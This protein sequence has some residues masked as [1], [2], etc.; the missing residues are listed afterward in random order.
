M[1][2]RYL[3]LALASLLLGTA[4][5]MPG[6]CPTGFGELIVTVVPD[7]WPNEIS[8]DLRSGGNV[9]ASGGV[10]GGT[11]CIPLNTC[12][13]FNMYDGYGDGITG[14][15]GY[16]VTLDGNTIASGGSLHGN[17]YG[18]IQTTE[19]NCPPGFSCGNPLVVGEGTH[20]APAADTWY[21]FT[22]PQSGSYLVTT[23]GLADCDTR[24]WVYD[25]CTGLV[26]DNSPAGTMYYADGGC[27]SNAELAQ[28]S[29]NL[30]EGDVVWIR[31]GHN[32]GDCAATIPWSVNYSGPIVGCTMINSCNYNPLA[33]VDDGS[34]IPW[35]DPD[36]PQAPDLTVDQQRLQLSL[37][38]GTTTVQQ[39]NCYIAEG[40][41]TGYGTREILRFDTR[42]ANIG[43]LDYY[44]G[45]P[46]ANP[47]QF[48][49]QNCHGH[50]HYKG[51]AEY[52]LYDDQGQEL[53]IGFKNG[54]CVMDIDCNGGG[55]GQYGCGNM[56]ISA[57][58]ADVYGSGTSCNWLDITGV[59]EGTYTLVVRTNW[60]NDPDA[61]GR[62]ESN[63]FNNWAQVCIRIDRTP[64]LAVSIE[65]DC[66]PYVD[67]LGEIYGS[68]QMDCM[69]DCAGLALIGDL[70]NDSYQDALDVNE[71]VTGIL[72]NDLTPVPC[73]DIDQD[74]NLTVTDAALLAYCNYWN[75]YNHPPDSAAVH[76]HCNF[77]FIEII[78]PYDT[79]TFTIGALDMGE[80][81]L[82][83]H[84]KNP[85]RKVLGYELK[86]SGLQITSV[87]GLYDPVA[88]P[89]VPTFAFGTGHIMCLSD[90]DSLI[91]RGPEYKPL[92]RVHFTAPSSM[93][94]IEE[95]IDV[96]NENYHNPITYLENNCSVSTGVGAAAMDQG[97]RVFPNPFNER[98]IISFPVANEVV[99]LTLFDLQGRALKRYTDAGRSG[100]FTIE[101]RDLAVGTYHYQLTG[102]VHGAG[103]LVVER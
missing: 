12:L 75:L 39:G 102:G 32:G 13:I 28:L 91:Q 43:Q 26:P 64:V 88:Y 9:I 41:L 6:G 29:A 36:C 73:N 14:N 2:P 54:F 61:L 24:I 70:N 65:D 22:A 48:E 59:E 94:C 46:Q 7:S 71:Y 51:Y 45:T 80:G 25:H 96:V 11:T 16:T 55:T 77:P 38:L 56:G 63:H 53:A 40:C 20:T 62:V 3:S 49:T 15:G 85:N 44:I 95:V 98:T 21:S 58:C 90:V 67:C 60:D 68:A 101:G 66:E 23:C 82:D 84:I 79:V 52:L 50:V 97:V 72:G 33:T 18:Y 69:G 19:I 17:N 89:A 1:K 42:I 92:C 76:D 8:W 27:S 30:G 47:D 83:I 37:N 74:G 86:M 5:A 103:K 99:Q 87:E 10:A 57:G 31:I 34:C 78:N 35:G 100:R 4:D 93:L 81:W